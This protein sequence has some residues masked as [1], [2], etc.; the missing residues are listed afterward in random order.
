MA[1]LDELTDPKVQDSIKDF[2]LLMLGAPVI[3]V[4]L[5][6][7]QLTMCVKRTCEMMQTSP[8]VAKWSKSVKLMVAQDGAL[9]LAKL[10][11]GKIRSKFGLGTKG[12]NTKLKSATNNIFPQD[13]HQLSIEGED[14]YYFWQLR[15]FGKIFAEN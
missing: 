11:L 4:E 15:V 14:A 13:G 7:S 1:K 9:A 5:D 8:K 6:E 10:I 12:V 2:V 3:K